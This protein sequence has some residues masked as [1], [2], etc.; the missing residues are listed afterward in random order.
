MIKF[1]NKKNLSLASLFLIL[2]GGIITITL[3]KVGNPFQIN[4]GPDQDPKN[5]KITNV[6]DSSF[7]VSFLT[8]AKV[9]GTI[10]YGVSEN[11][12]DSLAL[13]QRD[14]ISQKI[15]K[16][17]SHL[18]SVNNLE[19][20][21][22]YYF[23]I[24]SGDKKYLDNNKN[25]KA[26][27]GSIITKNPSLQSPLSGRV[28]L[29]DGS[30]PKEGLV[31][32]KANDS[33]NISTLIKEDGTYLIPLNTIRNS[34]NDDYLEFNPNTRISLELFAENLFTSLSVGLA[35]INPVPL[36]T[37][38]GSYDF[39]QE[40]SPVPTVTRK[41]TSGFPKFSDKAKKIDPTVTIKNQR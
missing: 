11:N 41:Q 17:T 15:G 6:S 32:L 13:D 39:T 26:K 12:L 21:K 8:T 16:Y 33:Q 36:I 38:S 37:I 5:V 1:I 19:P 31:F 7:S 27:T 14:Q 28:V 34:A 4:A 40:I 25:Y 2:I 23:S 35:D 10:N 24:T 18:I 3:V 30:F 29:P 22:T 20:N 9:I